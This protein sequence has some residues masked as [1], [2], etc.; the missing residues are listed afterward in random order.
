MSNET[1]YEHLLSDEEIEVFHDQGFVVCRGFIPLDIVEELRVGYNAAA[2][3][4]I[5]FWKD[6]WVPEKIL[7]LGVCPTNISPVG[8][9]TRIC[10]VSSPQGNS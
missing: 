5:E 4:E 3:G 8:R 9:T 6:R 2:R 10:V 7:K 1:L